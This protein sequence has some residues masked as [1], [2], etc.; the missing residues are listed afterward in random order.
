[1]LGSASARSVNRTDYRPWL[2]SRPQR[3]TEPVPGGRCD[4]P[5]PS[6]SASLL[7]GEANRRTEQCQPRARRAPTSAGEVEHR[8]PALG[9]RKYGRE[10]GRDDESPRSVLSERLDRAQPPTKRSLIDPE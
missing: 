9:N 4:R 5:L 10:T 7:D 8:A 1:M 2:F 3:T 6:T